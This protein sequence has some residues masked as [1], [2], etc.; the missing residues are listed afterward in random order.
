MLSA[1]KIHTV[2]LF[3]CYSQTGTSENASFVACYQIPRM[4]SQVKILKTT[5]VCKTALLHPLPIS[6]LTSKARTTHARPFPLSS[7]LVRLLQMH[8]HRNMWNGAQC[9]I[10]ALAVEARSNDI[11]TK[12]PRF[13]NEVFIVA[14]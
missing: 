10:S 5:G 6:Q 8:E 12:I 11:G 2:H 7:L 13:T 1:C 3:L 9:V 4:C 14:I